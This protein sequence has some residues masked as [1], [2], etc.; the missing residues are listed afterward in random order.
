MGNVR[1]WEPIVRTHHVRTSIW[2]PLL[3]PGFGHQGVMDP[4]WDIAAR[5]VILGLSGSHNESHIYRAIIE[6]ITLDQVISTEDMESMLGHNIDHYYAI[7]GGA[8]SP[9]WREML[10][11]VSAKPVWV[12]STIEASALGAG[13]I[14][15]CSAGWYSS[16]VEAAESMSGEATVV[17]PNAKHYDRYRELLELYKNL[18]HATAKLNQDLVAFAAKDV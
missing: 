11:N 13:M 3:C 1:A 12:S 6:A 9:L 16:I 18:Y 15:A 5:G 17:E 2:V 14:A 10:A 4:H 7:G 8:K